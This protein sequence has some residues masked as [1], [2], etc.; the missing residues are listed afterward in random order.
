VIGARLG[1]YQ[2][3]TPLGAG[4][5]GE[6]YRATDTTLGRDVAIKVLPQRLAADDTARQRFEREA[7][8]VAALSHPNILSIHDF[9]QQDGVAFAVMELLD[10]ETLRA[11]IARGAMPMRKVLQIGADIADG[12]AAAHEKGIVHRDLKPENVFITADGRVKILDFGLARQSSGFSDETS[13][14]ST[15]GVVTDPGTVMGTVGYMAPEQVMGQ[16]LDA[17]ADIFALGCVLY[18]MA[19]GRRAFARS[20]PPETMTAILR[21]EPPPLEHDSGARSTAFDNVVH[22]CLEKK[23]GER[24]QSARDLAFALR[25]IAGSTS[26]GERAVSSAVPALSGS[27]RLS[28]VGAIAGLAVGAI[29]LV[30]IGRYMARSATA[31]TAGPVFESFDMVTE[32]PGV[33]MTPSISPDGKSVVYAKTNGNDTA[34]YLIRVGGRKS[35]RLSGPAPADDS[36]PA[37][38]PDGD[39]I[40]FRSGRDGGGVFLMS[41]TGESVTRLTTSGY[42]PHWSPDG[43]Q[44]V[45]SPDTYVTPT[46]LGGSSDGLTIV[47]VGSGQTRALAIPQRALQPAWSPNGA[48]IAFFGV[49]PKR[50]GQRDI[51]TVA[52]DGSDLA[53]DGVAVTDDPA[54]DWS[55]TWSP[56]GR[57][58][59]FSSTRGGTMNLWRVAIDE[60]SGKVLGAPEPMTTPSTWSGNLSFSR[61][62]SRLVFS[63]LDYRSTLLRAP[64]DTDRG[65][66]TGPAQPILKGTRPIR[67]H[68]LSPDGTWVAFTQS[69]TQED[70][71]VVR[72]DGSEYRRL[73]DDAFRDRG[74]TWSPDGTRIAFYS[75][76]SGV[77]DLWQ[78]RPDGSGLTPITKA[79]GNPGFPIWSPDGS[80]IAFGYFTWHVIET[81]S[82]PAVVTPPEPP[83]GPSDR[84]MP[85]TW[86]PDGKRI[87]GGVAPPSGTGSA[88]G[89]YNLEARKFSTLPGEF[90]RP[91]VWFVPAWL[92]DS[93]RLLLRRAEGIAVVD[94]DTGAGHMIIPVGGY[95]IGESVGLSRD[96]R[97]ITYTETATDGDIWI[98]TLGK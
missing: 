29:A 84:F 53:Q 9:G 55:P 8:A 61:D 4:G 98:A 82:M 88:L 83:I 58:L 11:R 63:S 57:Y 87:A 62:G 22:R 74:P 23:P 68:S 16:P 42:F 45:T 30:L 60:Q 72:V 94:A 41:A 48:R 49:L 78:I 86:S 67:D 21:D 44:I 90:G 40:A 26:S 36:Q 32:D 50:G 27:R 77:Y 52:A 76:R 69:G 96:N 10:G 80:R 56:D 97:W 38:S 95:M 18:E 47:N 37:F 35:Q 24:F 66:V 6:V 64:F 93:R 46:D 70:L 7:R 1:Q 89:I 75:D 92:A 34:L 19:S 17:R 5:M 14:G 43:S 28:R 20:T 39:R 81:K 15:V 12:L 71:F 85:M 25:S 51:R 73:T 3:L 2:I 31:T 54:L 59:Y 13:A 79:N 33:E 91:G 65:E